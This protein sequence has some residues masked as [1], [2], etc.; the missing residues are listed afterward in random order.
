MQPGLEV[1]SERDEHSSTPEL[2]PVL[3]DEQNLYHDCDHTRKTRPKSRAHQRHEQSFQ[4]IPSSQNSGDYSDHP[5]Y[6][7]QSAAPNI[8][9][10][11]LNPFAA[12][13]SDSSWVKTEHQ[14]QLG[15]DVRAKRRVLWAVGGIHIFLIS[16]GAV[17]GGVDTA[18]A[19]AAIRQLFRIQ[20]PIELPR[21]R[22]ARPV[23][24]IRTNSR[25]AVT[26]YRTKTDCG[27]RLFYQDRDNH[28]RFVDKESAGANWT[29]LVII[30]DS[31]PYRLKNK[32]INCC[33]LI[34][35]RRPTELQFFYED[36]DG[37][38]RGQN[39]KFQ[40]WEWNNPPEGCRWKY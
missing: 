15:K 33:R 18:T 1:A 16:A 36:Q 26:G 27:I 6:G 9:N 32:R 37:I 28:L 5:T 31:L 35:I 38:V 29:E 30:L 10:Q 2:Q 11:H 7:S 19:K 14:T 23:K 40:V 4:T 25:L 3:H 22:Q 34:Y 21:I 8:E 39:I 17:L 24:S 13:S 12:T 20:H